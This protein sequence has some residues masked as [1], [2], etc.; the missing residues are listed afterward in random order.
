MYVILMIESKYYNIQHINNIRSVKAIVNIPKNT[1]LF[2]EKIKCLTNKTHEDWYE[3]IMMYELKNNYELFMDLEP[4]QRDIHIINDGVFLKNYKKIT[5][6]S[7]DDDLTL[8]YNKI[9]RNAFNI[10]INNENYC[11][12][13]YNG[14]MFNHSCKPNVSFKFEKR[15]K[16]MYAIFYTNKEIKKDAELTDNYFDINLSIA[17]RQHISK[18]YYGFEC[19][20]S[21]CVKELSL[22]NITEFF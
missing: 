18:T 5:V 16:D 1:V 3:Q 11:A 17:D 7:F 20:C 8:Y 12:I 13:L 15:G 21:K 10:K 22:N 19:K 2:D 4:K 9:I 6:K 14:R